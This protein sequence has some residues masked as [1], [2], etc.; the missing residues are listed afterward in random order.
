M[1]VRLRDH[2]NRLGKSFESR[3]PQMKTPQDRYIEIDGINTRF[4]VEGDGNPPV[5]LLHGLG[6]FIESWLPSFYTLAEQRKVYALDL[7]GHG[8]T[9]KPVN[10]SYQLTDFAR[11]VKDFLLAIGHERVCLAGHSLG[12]AIAAQ[13]TILFPSAVEKLVLVSSAGLGPDLALWLRL[14]TIPVLGEILACPIRPLME[15]SAHMLMHDPTLLTEEWIELGYRIVAPPETRRA[16]LKI[17][18]TNVDWLG[19]RSCQYRP[20]VQGL[21][22]I[23]IPVLVIWGRQDKLVPVKH[24]QVAAQTLP[25]VQ[26]RIFENCGHIPMLEQPQI[27]GAEVYGFLSGDRSPITSR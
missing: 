12:G 2:A 22:S 26:V 14:G 18:R 8:R 7:P 25:N 16:Y 20:I 4:W 3:E 24:A 10:H 23:T 21:P 1:N 5:I 19:Q 15:S 17:L 6:G 9:D 13:F 11:F 27:F